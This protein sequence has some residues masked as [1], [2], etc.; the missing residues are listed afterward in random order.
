MGVSGHA[1]F[2][3]IPF[4]S[5]ILLYHG[6]RQG[7]QT[8]ADGMSSCLISSHPAQSRFRQWGSGHA[9]CWGENRVMPIVGL[10]TGRKMFRPYVMG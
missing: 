10:R 5:K 9:Y 6:S 2:F 1:M 4:I 3:I 7:R 8:T